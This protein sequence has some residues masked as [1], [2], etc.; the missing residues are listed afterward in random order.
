MHWLYSFLTYTQTHTH[1]HTFA[2]IY[3]IEKFKL[4]WII[5]S[6]GTEGFG[7]L[8]IVT[9]KNKTEFP[10]KLKTELPFG[11]AMPLLGIWLNDIR[12]L[13]KY[14]H[15]HLHSNTIYK[16]QKTEATQGCMNGWINKQN[17]SF[18]HS[19]ILCVMYLRVTSNSWQPYE[20]CSQNPSH[21]SPIQFL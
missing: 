6:K 2:W 16:S 17:M 15:I 13:V 5:S 10:Q 11:S 18:T 9:D 19:A 4:I 3:I 12:I 7:L 1:T 21:S 20:W 14:F 8:K